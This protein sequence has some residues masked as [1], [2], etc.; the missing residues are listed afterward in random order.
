V[1]EGSVIAQ[2]GREGGREGREQLMPNVWKSL[3]TLL[4]NEPGVTRTLAHYNWVV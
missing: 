2:G 3:T 4:R 1:R